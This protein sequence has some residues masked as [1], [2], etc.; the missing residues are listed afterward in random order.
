MWGPLE[1]KTFSAL[2][3]EFKDSNA[4]QL[5]VDDEGKKRPGLAQTARDQ[6]ECYLDSI[7]A[8]CGSDPVANLTPVDVQM[9][10]DAFGETPAV[11]RVF[12]SVLSRL[13]RFLRGTIGDGH[14]NV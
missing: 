7:G 2:I 11:G 9:A 12:Q 5:N 4:F 13:S 8:A 6:Y 10:I 14:L 1:R 3:I